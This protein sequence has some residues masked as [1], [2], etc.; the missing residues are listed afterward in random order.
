MLSEANLLT[1]DQANKLSGRDHCSHDW[2]ICRPMVYVG[3]V[4]S[5]MTSYIIQQAESGWERA[6]MS[7]IGSIRSRMATMQ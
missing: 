4:M 2:G 5:Y 7:H 1:L 3:Q 6:S